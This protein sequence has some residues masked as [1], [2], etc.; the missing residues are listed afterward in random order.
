MIQNEPG[1]SYDP[2]DP[3]QRTSQ[4]FPTLTTA[5]IDLIRPF[6]E[7]QSLKE[8]T[9]LFERGERSVD[10]FVI[11]KGYIEIYEYVANGTKVITVHREQQFTGE[12]DLFNDREILVGGRMGVEGQVIRLSRSQF[13]RLMSAEPDVG[14]IIMRAFMLRRMGFISHQQASVTIVTEQLAGETLRIERFLER[15]GYPL[16]ILQ[17]EEE[18]SRQLLKDFEVSA[19]DLPAVLIHNRK[20]LLYNPSNKELA[21]ALGLVEKIRLDH[22]YDVTIIGAGPA[23]LSATVYAASEGLDTIL[24]EAEAPG[25]QAGTSSKIENY[26]GFPLGISGQSLAGRAQVQAH[27]FGATIALPYPVQALDCDTWPY[28]VQLN[29]EETIKTRT[30]IVATGARYR[31]LGLDNENRFEGA[32]IY[33]AATAME[34]DLCKNEEVVVIGGGNSAGQAAVFL[35]RFA[36]HVHILVRSKSLATSMSDYLVRRIDAASR[37]TLHTETEVVALQGERHLEVLTWRN[38][39][40]GA[41]EERVIR[42]LFLMIGAIPN[43]RWL[44]GCLKLDESGFVLTGEE[45]TQCG[46]WPLQRPAKMLE[47]SVPGVFATGDVRS[48]SIKRVASAVGEGAMTVSQLHKVLV[49]LGSE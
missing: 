42:H 40:T 47:T 33:Y 45:A 23:G 5:Q 27:K 38:N 25:G 20:E 34:G 18:R 2:N 28:K 10:F 32:G 29:D 13:R 39:T 14:E 15:N 35:S 17:F 44:D 36:K 43:T 1:V 41:T 7:E 9:V 19:D 12:L 3:Y 30:V 11:L 22:T 46:D 24:L 21:Q 31:K 49:E 8:G 6:G 26:L 37:I 4:I 48:G 16:E